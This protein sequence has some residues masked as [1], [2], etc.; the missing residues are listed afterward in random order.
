[1]EPGT[2]GFR[3]HLARIVYFACFCLAEQGNRT[4]AV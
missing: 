4:G 2:A 3:D 1:M